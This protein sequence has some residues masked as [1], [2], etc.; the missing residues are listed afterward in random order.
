MSKQIFNNSKKA[1]VSFVVLS[2]ILWSFGIPF[3]PKVQA[4]SGY[5]ISYTN[6]GGSTPDVF[7]NNANNA[8]SVV[9][10]D[11]FESG[12]SG[13]T[14][15]SVT[16]EILDG[17]N[18]SGSPSG[19][20]NTDLTEVALWLDADGSKTLSTTTDTFLASSSPTSW[21]ATTSPTRWRYTFSSLSVIIP[22]S[23]LMANTNRILITAKG[24][25]AAIAASSTP[26]TFNVQ[27][28]TAGVRVSTTSGAV[29]NNFPVI[30]G[31]MGSVY[32]SPP[33]RLGQEGAGGFGSSMIISE[34]QAAGSTTTDEFV[35]LYNRSPQAQ[36][37]EGY[38]ILYYAANAAD[39]STP[40]AAF[41]LVAA[42]GTT[43]IPG[44][45]FLLISHQGYD[46]STTTNHTYNTF[47][48][49]TSGFIL[50]ADATDVI[51]DKVGF[52]TLTAPALA[53][54]AQPAPSPSTNGSLERKARPASTYN[55][56]KPG[57]IEVS[58]GNGEDSNNNA[59]DFILRTVSDPQN[60]TSSVE[61]MGGGIGNQGSPIV[62]NEVFYNATSGVGWIELYNRNTEAS[63]YNMAGWKLTS[64]GKTYIV[65]NT[66]VTQAVPSGSFVV[67][68][69]NKAGT[70]AAAT[71]TSMSFY[72]GTTTWTNMN[73]YGGDVL[74]S[75]GANEVKDYVQYGGTGMAN[76]ASA[77]TSGQWTTG[78]YVTNCLYN[79]SIGRRTVSG[80]DYNSSTDW[81][82]YVTPNAGYANMGGDSTAPIKVTNVI[83][84]DNNTTAGSGLNGN[85]ITISWV[86][87]P[88]PDQSFDRYLLYLLPSGTS[89][90]TQTHSPIERLY[91]GQYQYTSGVA[92]TTYYGYTGGGFIT[93]DSAG[94]TLANGSYVAYVI[95]SDMA[96]NQSA[97]AISSAAALTGETY[98]VND[99]H[100]SPFVMHMG[101]WQ[102]KA[103][104]NIILTAR[105]DD[106]RGFGANTPK[107]VWKAG[108]DSSLP[109][110]TS[111]ATI[112]DCVAVV[113]EY[114]TC[115][116]PWGAWDSTTIIGYYLKATDEAGNTGYMSASPAADMAAV[117]AT[118]QAN[119]FKI[120][121][122]AA[123]DDTL[124]DFTDSDSNADLSGLAYKSDG[125]IF[126][127]NE[128]PYIYLEG[129]A[130]GPV[131]ATNST[132]AFSFADNTLVPGSYNLVAFN[133]GYMDMTKSVFKADTAADVYMNQGSMQLGQGGG[134]MPAVVWT[135]PNDGMMGVSKDIYCTGDCST[136]GSG[137]TPVMIA[138]SKE[139][140]LNTINDTD[141]SNAGSNIYLTTNGQDRVS[142][143]VKYV[144]SA[145]TTNEA[146]FYATTQKSL[147][148]GT[149]YSIVVTQNVTDK[150]GNPIMGGSGVGGAFVAGFNTMTDNSSMWGSGWQE[151]G[152]GQPQ[153]G[154]TGYNGMDYSN[155]GQGGQNMPAYV[156]GTV[157]SPGAF[158]I[159]RNRSLLVQFSE[160]MDST[161]I[162]S[163]SIK[164]Y[165]VANES[166]WTL[167]TA[168]SITVGLDQ[169]TKTIVT[170]TPATALDLN[171]SNHGWYVLKVMGS[172]KSASGVWL[173]NP[174]SCGTQNPDSCLALTASYE[175]K[176]QLNSDATGDVT[177]PTID[178]TYPNNN[179]GITAGTVAVNVGMPSVDIAFS[180][181]MLPSTISA[182]SITLKVGS[183]LVTGKVNY[184]TTGNMARL[185]TNNAL[186]PN[187]QYTLTVATSVQDLASRSLSAASV[188]NFKTG[189]A[190]TV[191]PELL[192][193]NADDYSMAITFSEPMNA[194]KQT[195]ADKWATS[196]LNP[197]NFYVK[198][199]ANI[200]GTMTPVSPYKTDSNQEK[201]LSSVTGLNFTYDEPTNTAV[202]K[203]F[204]F[205]IAEPHATDYQLYID[206][207]TDK[208]NNVISGSGARDVNGNN[209][210]QGPVK[211]SQETYGMLGPGSGGMMMMGSTAGGTGPGM[212]MGTMGMKMAGA[213][214]MN[215]IAGQTSMYFV[216][217]PI[218]TQIPTNGQIVLTFPTGFNVAS[219]QQDL[220]S[221]KNKDFNEWGAG[222][223]T[224]ACSDT[225]K[226]CGGGATTT[227]D[228]AADSTKGGAS[229]DGITVNTTART[230]TIIT[231]GTTSATDFLHF[232]IK[233][234]VNSSVPKEFGTDGY[235]IDI[236]TMNVS[237]V[238]LETISSMS[239][240]LQKGGEI[241]LS[242]TVTITQGD[243]V[244][245]AISLMVKQ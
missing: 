86:P 163:S 12:S 101:V 106:D 39:L 135:A 53:E 149:F 127:N 45:G 117:E 10:I 204:Q 24:T 151:Y 37:V 244:T 175:T 67:I 215:M 180:E 80:D 136:I 54:G 138:F 152:G 142:G 88:T 103:G 8:E 57:G 187:T 92:S 56:M 194:A 25:A 85:D 114:Y 168:V 55:T 19:F 9:A 234:I 33:I 148:A 144:Y 242:G 188:V 74:L 166:S 155:Y 47:N 109:D 122:L 173:G 7:L 118:V 195:D 91:G 49:A 207:V 48:I 185:V 225:A 239:F 167:G 183:S 202:I 198:G 186:S 176:F 83:L 213:M 214:P 40:T 227:G 211:S 124:G 146:R 32:F 44:G 126:A 218:T 79:Q 31:P 34:I 228:G 158:N 82:T 171:A 177:N 145:G 66:G 130:I 233:G 36:S 112:T 76:E 121:I 81:Q 220:F 223:I 87:D 111:G 6:D 206:N 102:A 21:T 222:T 3:A 72:T 157:P 108:T 184:D 241:T 217:A 13:N 164:L 125:S 119:P 165:P 20:T 224:F 162:S 131:Q 181:P 128:Q 46:G 203:G 26:R 212:N 98:S 41:P 99:D 189:G 22:A 71:S 169:S 196:I 179:D 120:D 64:S 230:V 216:D 134:Q 197:A 153:G 94:S 191:A 147:T 219:A 89:L 18:F 28:P 115:T 77:T 154:G 16:V 190:D 93:Q 245:G 210:T 232:D 172:A 243:G 238:L 69:W 60:A 137:E 182:Q 209:A 90:D 231:N 140:N 132:G 201:Q 61:I 58:Q 29:I 4:V 129:T 95:I 150:D 192:Y 27:I 70:D 17:M 75:T 62:I 113:S 73:T 178:G 63:N 2:T 43:T 221:P 35:E 235:T 133:T 65:P 199:L 116:I 170:V 59:M 78:D 14:I 107:V 15:N 84:A 200:L 5:D 237:G 52:G 208:S 97:A 159:Y 100:Q 42:N 30:G 23:Y 139:M 240:Y 156:K 193:A 229:N 236:K 51:I 160:A 174:Q 105:F 96:G 123:N 50:L 226:N 161:S 68:K 104:V 205:N 110:L 143:K 1:L 141:A 38:K 11:A